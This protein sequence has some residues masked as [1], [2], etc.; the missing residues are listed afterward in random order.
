VDILD[1]QR[2]ILVE[3][4]RKDFFLKLR[5]LLADEHI[6][7]KHVVEVTFIND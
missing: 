4:R 2:T 3:V 5:N 7:S 1:E 6:R